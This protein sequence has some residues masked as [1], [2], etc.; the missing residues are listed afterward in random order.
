[1]SAACAEMANPSEF[2]GGDLL[3]E[4]SGTVRAAPHR[5]WRV[6]GRPP[7]TAELEDDITVSHGHILLC[8]TSSYL[9]FRII[10]SCFDFFP[11]VLKLHILVF[12]LKH[13]FGNH[14]ILLFL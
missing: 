6:R 14:L 7:G 11:V 13:I 5:S 10:L 9:F 3:A 2:A 1:M 4:H 12:Y 8:L